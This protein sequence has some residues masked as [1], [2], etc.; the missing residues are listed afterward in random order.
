MKKILSLLLAFAMLFSFGGC[1]SQV[2][3]DEMLSMYLD[4]LKTNDTKEL[5]KYGFSE[6][7][8]VSGL[9]NDQKDNSKSEEWEKNVFKGITYEVKKAEI[10]EDGKTATVEISITNADF[11]QA[12]K[13]YYK[14]IL[15]FSYSAD[16][17]EKDIEKQLKEEIDKAAS[18]DKK[19]TNTA[20]VKMTKA[21]DDIWDI[22]EEGNDDFFNAL[23]GGMLDA[24]KN[25]E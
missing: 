16:T 12:I 1:G 24:L 17:T 18:N 15:N 9:F 21:E 4:A 2:G 3:P 19:V 22:D 25:I 11:G 5:E 14:K 10:A 6:E 20:K 23:M 13:N 8:I 7:S